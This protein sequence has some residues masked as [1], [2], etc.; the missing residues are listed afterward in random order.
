MRYPSNLL[1]LLSILVAILLVSCSSPATPTVHT[2]AMGERA[3]VGSLIYNVFS[4]R[5]MTQLG[6]GLSARVPASRFFVIRLSVVNSGS[7]ESSV[8]SL[9]LIDDTGQS[10]PELS[11]GDGVAQ[12]AGYLRRVKPAESLTG[13]VLFDAPPKHYKLQVADESEERKA[14]IDIPLSF[15]ED[16]PGQ[17][18][19]PM[20][21]PGPP[22][23][24]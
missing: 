23:H 10:Y 19:I 6:T 1:F 12:W 18:P 17:I 24:Q 20:P 21:E 2:Y 3:Q 8:P 14:M 4:T 13:N 7:R 11:N 9:T 5:W 22:V 15:S 16:A